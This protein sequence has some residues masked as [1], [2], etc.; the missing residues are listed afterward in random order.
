MAESGQPISYVIPCH[1]CADTI[2]DA[3]MSVVLGNLGS[4][5]EIILVDDASTDG[6]LAVLEDFAKSYHFIRLLRHK[7]NKGSA[8][9]GRNTGIDRA[10]NELI[11]CLDADNIL[12]PGSVPK[13]RDFLLL[14]RADAAAFQE[15]RY[16]KD[17]EGARTHTWRFKEGTIELIDALSGDIWP[18]PSGNYLFTKASWIKAGREIESVGGAFDSFAF[19]LRQL[20]IGLK[21]V[22]LPDSFYFHRYGYQS[23]FVRDSRT[24]DIST[25]GLQVLL[26]FLDQ[27]HPDDVKFVLNE[28]RGGWLT[29]EGRCQIRSRDG[30]VGTTGQLIDDPRANTDVI[31]NQLLFRATSIG[32]I[33]AQ[34]VPSSLW[35]SVEIKKRGY[36]DPTRLYIGRG[37]ERRDG[38]I[39]LGFSMQDA[40]LAADFPWDITKMSLPPLSLDEIW[41]APVLNLFTLPEALALLSR[42]QLWLRP[43][44][45]LVLESS[46]ITEPCAVIANLSSSAKQKVSAIC[47]LFGGVTSRGWDGWCIDKFVYILARLFFSETRVLAERSTSGKTFILEARKDKIARPEE[48]REASLSIL[49]EIFAGQGDAGADCA[50]ACKAYDQF[51]E[52]D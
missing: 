34:P 13:L 38:F 25:V 23:T 51:P 31:Q 52:L 22:T 8:A 47:A 20:A 44:G 37:A 4:G 12:A 29:A 3:V 14:Q 50:K 11:L 28:G 36:T 48:L 16:F 35:Y 2:H 5:D 32:T 42:W 45:R 46:D 9:A 6:T 43:G 39:N 18:G 26:P 27:F 41:V 17:K 30:R 21:M 1:N 10:Q 19:G 49:R 15:L 40:A 24:T 7:I 33:D